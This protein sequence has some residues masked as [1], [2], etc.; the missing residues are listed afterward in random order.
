[1]SSNLD[2]WFSLCPLVSSNNKTDHDI[3]EILLKVALNTIKQA[4]KHLGHD[5]GS[6]LRTPLRSIHETTGSGIQTIQT[7]KV[8]A[9]GVYISQSIRY[10]RACGSY[11]DIFDKEL[12]LKRKSPNQGLLLFKLR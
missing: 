5:K 10:S 2:R 6:R 9:Y 12:L 8:P 1:M 11:H 7:T 3:T 4:N